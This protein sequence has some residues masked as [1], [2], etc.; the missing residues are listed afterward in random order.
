MENNR[1]NY[2]TGGANGAPQDDEYMTMYAGN[3][4]ENGQNMQNGQYD[5]NAQYQQGYGYDQQGYQDQQYYQDYQ[6]YQ[7]YQGGYQQDHYQT[8]P[9]YYQPQKKKSHV[10]A[11][12]GMV[13]VFVVCVSAV[14]IAFMLRTGGKSTTKDD[15]DV[16]AVEQAQTAATTLATTPA[17]TTAP[18]ETT[19]PETTTPAPTTTKR[20]K[21]DAEKYGYVDYPLT[22]VVRVDE[23]G[24]LPIR[25]KADRYDSNKIAYIPDS[26]SVTVL[27]YKDTGSEVW[28]RVSY[29]GTQGWCRGGMLQPADLNDIY[30]SSGVYAISGLTNWR[31]KF[32]VTYPT[33]SEDYGDATINGTLYFQPDLSSGV[34]MRLSSVSGYV[35]GKDGDFYFVMISNGI[36]GWVNKGQLTF[37]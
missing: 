7:N 16:K 10:I 20:E 9:N 8:Q 31:S 2:N 21:T 15:G 18:P 6:D 33:S 25:D 32:V 30:S 17:A 26:T 1:N 34:Q 22:L 11:I 4:P 19:A 29:G 36:G 24:Q 5:P 23:A 27:G 14:L 12:A 37:N 28:F 35:S 3:E 13:S